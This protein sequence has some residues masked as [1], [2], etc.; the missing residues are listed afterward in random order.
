MKNFI[1]TALPVIL[2]IFLLA[3]LGTGIY[4]GAYG[5]TAQQYGYFGASGGAVWPSVTAG[6]DDGSAVEFTGTAATT[7]WLPSADLSGSTDA[8]FEWLCWLPADYQNGGRLSDIKLYWITDDTT[9]A[10]DIDVTLYAK[11]VGD[12]DAASGSYGSGINEGAFASGG[13]NLLNVDTFSNSLTPTNSP[14]RGDLVVFKIF[15]D[16]SGC[17]V[18]NT[19]YLALLTFKYPR[20]Q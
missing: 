6:G 1:K 8:T 2:A 15:I 7:L 9:A 12:G 14:E 4:F 17:T 16:D 3:S 20:A 10:H 13:A 19:L 11:A 5:G 18:D